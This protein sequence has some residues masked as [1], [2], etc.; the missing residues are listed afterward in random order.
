[1]HVL[2]P[3]LTSESVLIITELTLALLLFSDASMVRLRDVEAMQVCLADCCSLGY[4]S[5][6]R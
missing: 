5:R 1:L 6:D 3:S 2:P 4:H